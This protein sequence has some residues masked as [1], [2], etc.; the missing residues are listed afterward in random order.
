LLGA[1]IYHDGD[2]QRPVS[3]QHPALFEHERLPPRDLE[4]NVV[5]VEYSVGEP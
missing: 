5:R 1:A 4:P 2:A 3:T